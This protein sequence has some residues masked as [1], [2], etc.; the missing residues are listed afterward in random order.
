LKISKTAFNKM[1]LLNLSAKPSLAD[2]FS[3]LRRLVLVRPRILWRGTAVSA[4][5]AS[6]IT[7]MQVSVA[8]AIAPEHKQHS[9]T[10]KIGAAGVAGALSAPLVCARDLIVQ[11]QGT[12][13]GSMLQTLRTILASRGIVALARGLAPVIGRETVFSPAYQELPPI[14]KLFIKKHFGCSDNTATAVA[15]PVAGLLATAATQPFDVVRNMMHT[16]INGATYKNTRHA[17]QTLYATSGIIGF[18]SGFLPRNLLLLVS[19]IALD[20]SKMW[21]TNLLQKLR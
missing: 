10:Y 2:R 12:H 20:Q 18:W 19:I 21:G 16:D 15:Y 6:P 7:S 17:V 13:G 14:L 3:N 9:D 4:L 1:H 11:Y 5:A 8:K